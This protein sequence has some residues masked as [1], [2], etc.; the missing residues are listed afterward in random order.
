MEQ[1]LTQGDVSFTLKKV[2]TEYLISH[3]RTILL[4]SIPPTLELPA[5][6]EG[7]TYRVQWKLSYGPTLGQTDTDEEE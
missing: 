4:T 5:E 7:Y 6:K 2:Q 3:L 1:E